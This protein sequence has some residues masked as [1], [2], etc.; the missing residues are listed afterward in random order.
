M[1]QTTDQI[2][3]DIDQ[4]REELKANLE[5]LETRV[6]SAA[7]WRHHVDRHPG[8]MILISMVAGA[9]ISALIGKR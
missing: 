6:K 4:T 9:L 3:D 7:D 1:G 8:A 5:E 2:V